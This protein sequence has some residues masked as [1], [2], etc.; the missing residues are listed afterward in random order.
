MMMLSLQLTP[1]QISKIGCPQIINIADQLPVNKNYTWPEL[2]GI[3]DINSL[4]RI[5]LHHDAY[6]KKQTT[7]FNDLQMAIE[8]ANGHIKKTKDEP[9]GEPGIAYHGMVRNGQ[10]YQVNDI[11]FK[12]YGVANNNANTVHIMVCGD[13]VNFDTLTDPDRSALYGLIISVIG[14]LPNFKDI[15]AHKE[16]TATSCPGYDPNKVRDDVAHLQILLTQAET[17]KARVEKCGRINSQINYMDSLI[18]AGELDGNA[19]WALQRKEAIYKIM[20]GLKLL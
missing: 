20:D 13:Y 18:A 3:R 8:I 19:I 4:T 9:K 7:K 11:L 6:P 5:V 10:A 17:W 14:A 16:L 12:T 15:K 2:T 1:N